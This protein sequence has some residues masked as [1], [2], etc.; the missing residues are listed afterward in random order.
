MYMSM[1]MDVGIFGNPKKSKLITKNKRNTTP[2]KHTHEDKLKHSSI[3]PADKRKNTIR[4]MK[5][6]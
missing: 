3:S 2:H 4:K 6:L 5:M 1:D